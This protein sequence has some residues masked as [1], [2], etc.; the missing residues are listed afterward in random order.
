TSCTGERC[1]GFGGM[2]EQVLEIEY[3]DYRGEV[4]ILSRERP[5]S[6]HPHFRDNAELLEQYGEDYA[7]YEQFKNA[8]F[9]RFLKEIDLMIGTEGQ[10]GVITGAKL[11]LAAATNV[12]YIFLFLRPW[13]EDFS[14]HLEVFERVQKY[15][16]KIFACEMIDRNSLEYLSLEERPCQNQDLVFLEIDAS[17][18]ETVYQE[19]LTTLSLPEESLVEIP[20]GKVRDLRMNV[21]RAIFE[22]NAK[23]GVTKKG[24]D[25]QVSPKQFEKLLH[26]Y[27]SWSNSGVAYNLFGHFGDAHLHFNFMP[28]QTEEPQCQEL[29]AQLYRE[30]SAWGGSPFAEHGIGLLK[31]KFIKN[32]Y[33][34]NQKLMFGHLKEKMDPHNQFFPG[35]YMNAGK[36]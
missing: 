33:G 13:Q 14:Q 18:F 27:K 26:Y 34:E 9:P 3:L 6:A 8:P 21:P 7:P 15:R 12:H 22:V 16:S 10:L 36:A 31:Q 28:T 24:T 19:L 20:M 30:V 2:R 1:F 11:K 17:E 5:L 35:G 23:M 25:V 32:Y 29:L 4:Q